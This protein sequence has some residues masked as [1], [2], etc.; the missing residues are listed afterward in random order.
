MIAPD[1]LEVGQW[2]LI[3]AYREPEIPNLPIGMAV[4]LQRPRPNGCPMEVVSINIP[5]VMFWTGGDVLI[6]DVRYCT[7]Q[8][9]TTEYVET[10]FKLLPIAAEANG[11]PPLP[12]KTILERKNDKSLYKPV[13]PWFQEDYPPPKAKPFPKHLCPHCGLPLL[14]NST[15]DVT[16]SNPNCGSHP[17]MFGD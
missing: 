5:F 6:Q 17:A 13:A 14:S 1:D 15:G 4:A 2:V 9:V 16:C 12:L 8:K 11:K 3:N 7:F 10:F